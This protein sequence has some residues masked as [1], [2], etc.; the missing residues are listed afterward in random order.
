MK[1]S[2]QVKTG[3]RED[4]VTKIN[5]TS[6]VVTVKARPIDGKANEAVIKA[7]AKFFGVAKSRIDIISGHSSSKKIIVI[8]TNEL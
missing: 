4:G 7:L 6:F 8:K 5:E 2:V 3:A 1:L